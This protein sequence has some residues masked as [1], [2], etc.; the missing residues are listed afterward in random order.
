MSI[1][2]Y[3]VIESKNSKKQTRPG[4]HGNIIFICPDMLKYFKKETALGKRE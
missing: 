4:K 3:F 2:N 1:C